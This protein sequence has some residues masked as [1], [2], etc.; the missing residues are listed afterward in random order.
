MWWECKLPWLGWAVHVLNVETFNVQ[1]HD[2]IIQLCSLFKTVAEMFEG[3]I[4]PTY[5]DEWWATCCKK[6][7]GSI[8]GTQRKFFWKKTRVVEHLQGLAFWWVLYL[9][10]GTTIL[11]V[12]GIISSINF[13]ILHLLQ[14]GRSFW[15]CCS[16]LK[17]GLLLNMAA[18]TA[19]FN[20]HFLSCLIDTCFCHKKI[21]EKQKKVRNGLEHGGTKFL[22]EKHKLVSENKSRR[23]WFIKTCRACWNW[24]TCCERSHI[25]H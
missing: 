15:H 1:W 19:Y 4:K 25:K 17:F 5:P 3:N 2:L 9:V 13:K 14:L 23:R 18:P 21:W 16:S 22:E 24:R 20:H 7:S 6:N 11:L 12:N 10:M 8:R